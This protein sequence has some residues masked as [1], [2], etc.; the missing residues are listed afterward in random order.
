MEVNPP[1]VLIA[2]TA[3]RH[4]AGRIITDDRDFLEIAKVVEI[5][6]VVYI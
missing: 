5:E 2:A 6:M 3:A 4:G 1:D